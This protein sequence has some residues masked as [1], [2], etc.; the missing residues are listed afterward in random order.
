MIRF[1]AYRPQGKRGFILGVLVLAFFG[2]S[3]ADWS[4]PVPGINTLATDYYPSLT[5]DGSIFYF[6]SSRH[7]NGDVFV[8]TRVD[9]EWT[10][11]VNLEP[12]VIAER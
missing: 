7:N 3:K 5:T 12:P 2:T 6:V 8:S 9:G 10:T 4:E 1:S 11:P